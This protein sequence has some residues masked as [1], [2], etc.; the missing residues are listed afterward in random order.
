MTNAEF[1]ATTIPL[2]TLVER[3]DLG[4][5]LL[6]GPAG[7]LDRPVRWAH[8]SELSDPV[9]Y[10]LGG[11]LLLCCG[12][13]LPLD[14]QPVD[15]YVA[16]LVDGGVSALGFGVTPVYAAVPPLLIEACRR[17]DLPLLEIPSSTPFLAVCRAV[18]EELSNRTQAALRRLSEAQRALTSAAA[19]SGAEQ[20][21]LAEL[22][23][24]LGGWAL[25]VE[26]GAAEQGVVGQL[27]ERVHTGVASAA[28]ELADGTQVVAQPAGARVLVAGKPDRFDVTDRGIIAVAIA[29]LGAV[30]GQRA[31]GSLGALAAEL[32]TG[33]GAAGQLSA[34]F[35]AVSDRYR[36]VAAESAEL[37]TELDTPLIAGDLAIVARD[38]DPA[39]LAGLVGVSAAY[40]DDQLVAA[41]REARQLLERA[42]AAGRSLHADRA[43]TGFAWAVRPEAARAVA[44]ALLSPIEEH[45]H[46]LAALRTWL[47]Q[48]G[49]WDRTAAAL[50]VH[51]NSVRH[52]IGRVERLLRVDL[53]DPQ[54]RMELWFAMQWA[55]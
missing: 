15:N 39:R 37:L 12:V 19:R 8:V 40:S 18:G 27:A 1:L 2:R 38:V 10:L 26:Q 3:A 22:G 47:A 51:R 42:R 34:V 50:G 33:G 23:G 54:A 25:L 16:G 30:A 17:H 49:N 7:V 29:L 44:S 24:W 35:G 46:L 55:E 11:E 20:R 53:T 28:T 31:T 48:H 14:P 21:V 32:L 5:D 4:T 52:R 13:E 45:P 36:V 9:P 6:V 43:G 41:A